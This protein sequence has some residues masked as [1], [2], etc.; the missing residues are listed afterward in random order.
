MSQNFTPPTQRPAWQ[1]LTAL[2]ATLPPLRELMDQPGRDRLQTSA[3]GI[4]LD[5][6]R[7]AVNDEVLDHLFALAET[8]QVNGQAQAMF[9]GD[10]INVTENR[11]VLHVAQSLPGVTILRGKFERNWPASPVLRNTSAK[12]I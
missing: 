5:Y 9:R 11:P 2:A 1:A 7:Q 12:G 4:T 3:V 10:P 6:L 8:S